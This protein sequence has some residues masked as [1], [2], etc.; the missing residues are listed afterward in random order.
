MVLVSAPKPVWVAS[1][2]GVP[3]WF[4]GRAKLGWLKTLKN[5]VSKRKVMCSVIGIFLVTYSSE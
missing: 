5:W 2:P 3:A 4:A 1:S